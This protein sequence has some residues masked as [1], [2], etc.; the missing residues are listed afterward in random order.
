MVRPLLFHRLLY[1]VVG[2]NYPDQDDSIVSSSSEYPKSRNG[3]QDGKN[4][5]MGTAWLHLHYTS[6]KPFVIMDMSTKRTFSESGTIPFVPSTT[7]LNLSSIIVPGGRKRFLCCEHLREK[8]NPETREE[9][10]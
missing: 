10:A 8:P 7:R 2:Q 1:R 5:L 3:Y 4:H 9:Q 6:L